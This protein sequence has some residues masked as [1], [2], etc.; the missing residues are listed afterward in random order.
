MM[1]LGEMS[2]N[3]DKDYNWSVIVD[4]LKQRSD[5]A[6]PKKSIYL[7]KKLDL[8]PKKPQSPVLGAKF[9]KLLL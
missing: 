7:I 4:S 1:P 9:N 6:S 5:H 2:L 8:P 3:S